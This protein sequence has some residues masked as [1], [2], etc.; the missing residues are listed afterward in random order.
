MTFD[1]GNPI[2]WGTPFPL[3]G[4]GQSVKIDWS[5]TIHGIDIPNAAVAFGQLLD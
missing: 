4:C 5:G 3:Q 2:R 1:Y